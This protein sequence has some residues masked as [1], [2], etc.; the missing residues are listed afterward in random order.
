MSKILF[1]GAGAVGSYI[2]SC[3]SR[4]GHDVTLVDPWAEHVDAINARGISVTGPHEPFVARP[5]AVHL[6]EAA[7]LPSDFEMAIVT[8][9][10]YDTAWAVQLAMR[11]LGTKGFVVSAQNCWNDPL[12]ASIA[13]AD[14]AVGLVMS[15]IGVA[16]WKPG[17]VERGAERGS[18]S[19]HDVFRAGEHDGRIT[20]RVKE[21][22]EMLSV[23]DG[24]HPTDNLWGERWSKLCSNAMGN[25]VQGMSGLG[26][27]EVMATPAGRKV[28]INL[29]AESARVGLA[30]GYRVPKIGAFP[31]ETWAAADQA[32]TYAELDKKVTP[33]LGPGRNWRASMA[34]DVIKRRRT[35]IEHMN[36]FVVAKGREA[37]VATPMSEVVVDI[38]RGIDAGTRE[39]SPATIDEAIRRSGVK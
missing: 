10:S 31:A 39:P 29:A 23:V 12:V 33:A 14:R 17:E 20:P 36:G 19:G 24:A 1:V 34:Q 28:T 25:P 13:G 2:G 11:H 38:V 35:E 32:E 16:L 27:A 15:R 8:M 26:T 3:L 22:A 9:K 21:L 4:A 37:S 18:S 30:L 7:K 6:H 5:K